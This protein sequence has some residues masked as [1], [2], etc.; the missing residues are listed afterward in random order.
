MVNLSFYPVCD[1]FFAV[2]PTEYDRSNFVDKSAPRVPEQS[3]QTKLI[4]RIAN[5][6]LFSSHLRRSK[7]EPVTRPFLVST[8]MFHTV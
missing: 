2:T 6:S 1:E 3:L 5:W 8:V 4:L 7:P